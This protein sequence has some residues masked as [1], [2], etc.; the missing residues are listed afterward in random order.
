MSNVEH[1]NHYNK[2]GRKEC[3]QEMI[4]IFGVEEVKIFCKLNVYKYMYRH[5]LKNGQEDV[6]KADNYQRMFVEL[7]GKLEEV[8][9][10]TLCMKD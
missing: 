3:I 9:R 7:G 2:P 1:P 10:H 4:E 6:D 5:D 8:I